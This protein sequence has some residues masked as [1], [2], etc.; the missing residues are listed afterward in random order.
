M[1]IRSETLRYSIQKTKLRM[2]V[3]NDLLSEI[4]TLELLPNPTPSDIEEIRNK[5]SELQ[6][7]RSTANEGRII[8]S[9]AK[10][11]E[12]GERASSSY[13]LKLEKRNFESKLIPCLNT[14][15]S[16]VKDSVEILNLLN[17]HYNSLYSKGETVSESEIEQN[18]NRIDLPKLSNVQVQDLEKDVTV[19]ELG[20]TLMQFSNNKSPGSDGFPYDFFKVFWGEIKHFVHRSLVFGLKNGELS[21]TQ[22]EGLITLVPKPSKPRNLISSWRPI[23]L[24]NSTYKILAGTMANR[25]KKVLDSII[26]PDQTAFLKNRFIGENIRTIYDVLWE[27]Q[28]Q[29][30][31]GLLLSIDFKTAFDVMRWDFLEICLRKFNFGEKFIGIFRCL[32]KNIFSRIIYNGHLSKQ[33]INLEQGCRQGDPISCYFFIIGAEVLAAKMRQNSYIRGIRIKESEIKL[34]QYAD[35]TAIFL[36]GSED[37][38]SATFDELG[39]FAKYSGLAPNISKCHAMW[40]GKMAYSTEKICPDLPLNWVTKLKLLGVVLKPDC[41]NMVDENV[42]LKKDSILRTIAMWKNRNLTLVGKITVV[43][44]LLLSQITHLISSLPDPSEK[45]INEISSILFTFIWGSKRNPLKRVRLCQPLSENG[46]SMIDISSYIKSLKIKWI[47]RL[48]IGNQHSSWYSIIPTNL[49]SE[50]IWNYGVVALKKIVREISNPFWRDVVAAWINFSRVFKTPSESLS[51]ENI[52]NSDYTKFKSCQYKGWER[53]GVRVIGDLF[54]GNKMLT[55]LRFKD[56]YNIQCNYLDYYSLVQSLPK[57]LRKD[58][59]NWWYHQHPSIT[60]R[61]LFILNNTSFTK[62]FLTGMMKANNRLQNDMTRIAAKWERDVGCFEPLSVLIVKNSIDATRYTS[63]QF[64]LVMRILTTNSFLSLIK[65]RESNRCTFCDADPETLLHLFV[66]CRLVQKLWEDISRYLMT[67]G[68]RRPCCKTK[69]FADKRN[70]LMTHI[71]TLA[72]FVINDARYKETQPSF[73]WFK[74]CLVRDFETERLIATQRKSMNTFNKKWEAL[75]SDL[76]T[77][78]NDI[79]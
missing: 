69:L 67:N 63:F 42:K 31:K 45:L 61:L 35:D 14:G 51:N 33:N 9:R 11:Y 66:T 40:I 16:S 2:R 39:W 46:L 77:N 78:E 34:V 18:V 26:H 49:Q 50:F 3:E 62:I 25:L 1:K 15:T 19:E 68:M 58:Q 52:F 36:N 28:N 60:A 10:W 29:K 48:L 54:E 38:L 74:I 5:Q 73:R 59:P 65:Y 75:M 22:R 13:F 70:P 30:Q 43:K 32:H 23:T 6:A 72:K 76:M 41:K 12:E 56:R 17:E 79:E 20:A 21:I 7:C 37:S 57:E 71:V 47:K 53:K 55:W 44:S 8:R 27:A 64:K 24:L 4:Q